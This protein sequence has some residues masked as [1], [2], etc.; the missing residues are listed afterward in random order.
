MEMKA[1]MRHSYRKKCIIKVGFS[2]KTARQEVKSAKK[3]VDSMDDLLQYLSLQPL[4]FHG[5]SA[6]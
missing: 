6:V 5:L 4:K 1:K 3:Y 2:T